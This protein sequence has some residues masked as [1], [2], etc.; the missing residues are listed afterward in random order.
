MHGYVINMARSV[1]RRTRMKTELDRSGID[2][3]LVEAVDGRDLDLEVAEIVRPS[4]VGPRCTTRWRQQWSFPGVA[5]CSLSHVLV[6]RK[7]L[8]AGHE[9]ALV[10]EDDVILPSDL[11]S[12]AGTVASH[13]SGADVALLNFDSREVCQMR[14]EASVHL[15]ESRFLALPVDSGQLSSSAAYI[16]TREACQRLEELM[17]PVRALPD[18][19]GFFLEEG[20]IDRVRCVVPIPVLK[21]PMFESTIEHAS[22]MQL[23]AR[24]R[25]MVVRQ[26]VVR[27][28]L[29]Y[30]RERIFRRWTRTEFVGEPSLVSTM[31]ETDPPAKAEK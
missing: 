23:K 17:S 11:D 31:T 19:W 22:P 25:R 1:E 29:T 9:R 28:A 4:S 21:N 2:Y 8:E 6:Y 3:E 30:R 13:L 14:T 20:A 15:P 7:I 18:E 26:P 5:A 16:L 10:L 24:L 27:R 12:F